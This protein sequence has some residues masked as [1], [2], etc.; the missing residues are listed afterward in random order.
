[1][2]GRHGHEQ[3]VEERPALDDHVAGGAN[4]DQRGEDDEAGDHA[5]AEGGDGRAA[6]HVW[7]LYSRVEFVVS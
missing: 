4:A 3:R 5:R 1:M 2:I 7:E 6:G